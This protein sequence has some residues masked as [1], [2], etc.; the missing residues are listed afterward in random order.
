MGKFRNVTGSADAPDPLS[1]A[2]NDRYRRVGLTPGDCGRSDRYP[3]TAGSSL[4][5]ARVPDSSP[6]PGV[7]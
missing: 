7:A 5:N 1:R 6:R 4:T 3:V 2:S